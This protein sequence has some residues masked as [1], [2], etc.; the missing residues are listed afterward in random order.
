LAL[1]IDAAVDSSGNVYVT[2]Q[3]SSQAQ[4]YDSTGTAILPFAFVPGLPKGITVDLNSGDV[5]VVR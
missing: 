1:P 4:K 5:F 3:S 2:A